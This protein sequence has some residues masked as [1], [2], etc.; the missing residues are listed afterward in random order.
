MFLEKAM[1]PHSSTLAWKVPRT[2]EPDRQRSL[3]GCS[4]WG[5][6]ELDTTERTHTI[7]NNNNKRGKEIALS[8]SRVT[9]GCRRNKGIRIH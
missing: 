9:K 7:K 6:K 2:E 4:P 8:Y 1:A 3:A 5:H